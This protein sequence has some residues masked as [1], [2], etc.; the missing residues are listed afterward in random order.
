MS[1]GLRIRQTEGT[2]AIKYAIDLST[3]HSFREARKVCKPGVT[4]LAVD[5]MMA[6]LDGNGAFETD[7]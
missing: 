3:G 6:T 4:T 2:Y 7:V 5:G 1:C